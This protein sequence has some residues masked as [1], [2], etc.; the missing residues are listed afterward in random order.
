[1]HGAWRKGIES[2]AS[3]WASKSVFSYNVHRLHLCPVCKGCFRTQ[4][5]TVD[6]I[7]VR[8]DV[9]SAYYSQSFRIN[10]V[11]SLIFLF[12]FICRSENP[13]TET[14]HRQ[15]ISGIIVRFRFARFAP[16]PMLHDP[17]PSL[18]ARSFTFR[19]S[20][21]SFRIPHALCPMPSAPCPM[22]SAPCHYPLRASAYSAI[23]SIVSLVGEGSNTVRALLAVSI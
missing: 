3:E 4:E 13:G 2:E 12:D 11:R 23:S 14:S 1:M 10:M 9:F 6:T 19:L 22:P 17:C 20:H 16:C 5:D 8:A 18:Y 7:K 15:S 21:S